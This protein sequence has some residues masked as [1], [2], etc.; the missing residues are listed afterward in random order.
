MWNV[1]KDLINLDRGPKRCRSSTNVSSG[2][3]EAIHANFPEV[4]DLR[5][6]FFEK[7]RS[8]PRVAW[9]RLKCGRTNSEPTRIACTKRPA[10]G[11]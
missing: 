9:A 6:A 11:R 1:A 7:K 2:Q 5:R 8:T 4:A 3:W 10:A